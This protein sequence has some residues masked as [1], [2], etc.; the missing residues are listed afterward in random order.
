M[1]PSST[2]ITTRTA[3]STRRFAYAVALAATGC[4]A[5]AGIEEGTLVTPDASTTASVDASLDQSTTT[6]TGP[7]VDQSSPDADTGPECEAGYTACSGGCWN[8]QSDPNH[9]G[10]TCGACAVP[11]GG[12]VACDAGCVQTCAASGS[13][14]CNNVCVDGQTNAKNCGA[15]GHSCVGGTCS[16]G[17]CQ[18][19]KVAAP[20]LTKTPVDIASDGTNLVWADSGLLKVMQVGVKGAVAIT[21]GS[22]ADL[23]RISEVTMRG[24]KVAWTTAG[25]SSATVMIATEGQADSGAPLATLGETNQNPWALAPIFDPTTTHLFFNWYYRPNDGYSAQVQAITLSTGLMGQQPLGVTA[26]V[27][28]SRNAI[29]DTYLFWGEQ[30][31]DGVGGILHRYTLATGATVSTNAN[32]GAGVDFVTNDGKYVYWLG[33]GIER[34][35]EAAMETPTLI[36][37]TNLQGSLGGLATDGTYLYFTYRTAPSS[38]I[39]YAPVSGGAATVLQIAAGSPA[40]IIAVNGAI[41]WIDE[42]TATIYGQVFP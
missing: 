13:I 19:W 37:I 42:G 11:E 21:I 28:S 23:T 20:P 36:P 6:D 8:T 32:P 33:A 31:G 38:S 41:Y 16:A 2:G 26:A 30:T 15:C 34:T 29:D 24:G 17:K 12:T 7:T 35:S 4:N 1:D 5:L 25:T 14:A 9:C 39:G 40:P 27:P 10:S 22:D 18:P 3:S